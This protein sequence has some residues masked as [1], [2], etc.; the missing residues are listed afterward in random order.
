MWIFDRTSAWR[1]QICE[2]SNNTDLQAKDC[3]DFPTVSERFLHMNTWKVLKEIPPRQVVLQKLCFAC[4]AAEF[5][6]VM[7]IY[8]FFQNKP[9][10][11]FAA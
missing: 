10:S 8:R 2:P 6:I 1:H 3:I 11:S 7:L 5:V 9:K 4:A